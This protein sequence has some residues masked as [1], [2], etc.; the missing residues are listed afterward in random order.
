MRRKYK[1]INNIKSFIFLFLIFSCAFSQQLRWVYTHVD[2]TQQAST[3]GI[4]YGENHNIYIN[5]R[6]GP[7]I[8]RDFLLLCLDTLG[9]LKWSY[10]END[11]T[12][13]SFVYKI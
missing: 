13:Y 10:F 6:I 1:K 7:I 4:L 2:T 12:A 3:G 9:T 8:S 5:G 11:N